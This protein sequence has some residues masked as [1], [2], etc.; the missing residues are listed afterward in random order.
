MFPNRAVRSMIL[1]TIEISRRSTSERVCSWPVGRLTV[2]GSRSLGQI[3][4]RST[5]RPWRWLCCWRS[6]PLGAPFAGGRGG[7]VSVPASSVTREIRVRTTIGWA[8]AIT[9]WRFDAESRV[10]LSP[11]S[12]GAQSDWRCDWKSPEVS[13]DD[14]YRLLATFCHRP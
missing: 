1:S 11:R 5:A 7:S 14:L 3:A 2:D 12:S 13:T 10:D 9:A 6:W 4:F 8:A